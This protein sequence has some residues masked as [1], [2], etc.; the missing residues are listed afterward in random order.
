MEQNETYEFTCPYCNSKY[1]AEGMP[2]IEI[3]KKI[4]H[5]IP[6]NKCGKRISMIENYISS[7]TK[8]VS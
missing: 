7:S 4:G 1:K 5:T 8:P 6:C 2:S 3:I